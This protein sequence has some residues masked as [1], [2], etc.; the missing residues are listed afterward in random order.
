MRPFGAWVEVSWLSPGAG[1][2]VWAEQSRVWLDRAGH[3]SRALGRLRLVVVWCAA[4][5]A[6][7]TVWRPLPP[8]S[9][10]WGGRLRAAIGRP[11]RP[12]EYTVA[13]RATIA[14]TNT[15]CAINIMS[16]FMYANCLA[17]HVAM[18]S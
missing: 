11:R 4:A 13:P 1:E 16:I 14:E 8:A 3:Q 10:D 2:G 12:R 7:E 6:G 9:T 17:T 5:A 15:N 18:F